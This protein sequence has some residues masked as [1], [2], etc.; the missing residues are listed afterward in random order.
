MRVAHRLIGPELERQPEVREAGRHVRLD[1]DVLGLEVA[2]CDGRLCPCGSA[3]PRRAG[4]LLVE[5]GQA[6]RHGVGDPAEVVP[7]ERVGLEVVA[8]RAALV[9][10]GHQPEL[11]SQVL[12]TLLDPDE[13]EQSAR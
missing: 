4:D 3:R 2:V 10:R 8:Q 11:Q 7:G 5:V 13:P 12:A 6:G 1:E 9:E